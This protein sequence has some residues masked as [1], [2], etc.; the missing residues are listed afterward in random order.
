MKYLLPVLFVVLFLPFS[1]WAKD[2]EATLYYE[3]YASGFH[4]MDVQIHIKTTKKK[5]DVRLDTEL[6]GLLA[7]FVPWQGAFETRGSIERGELIPKYHITSATWKKET[8]LREYFYNASGHLNKMTLKENGIAQDIATSS[9]LSS[10]TTDILTLF[11]SIILKGEC[12]FEEDIFDGKRRFATEFR[13]EG[14]AYLYKSKINPYQGEAELCDVEI[15]PKGGKWYKKPRGWLAIQE[16]GREKGKLPVIYLAR[17]DEMFP[18]LPVKGITVSNYGTF[19]LHLK[20]VVY[21]NQPIETC[22]E[23]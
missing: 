4:V 20:H 13:G 11:L 10:D 23:C 21:D 9:E 12:G 15:T 19:L 5:Y 1:A 16:Q 8:E 22:R 7:R 18:A 17:V 2:R 14:D 3:V 6:T